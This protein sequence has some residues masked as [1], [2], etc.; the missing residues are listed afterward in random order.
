MRGHELSPCPLCSGCRLTEPDKSVLSIVNLQ[1]LAKKSRKSLDIG[2]VTNTAL[3]ACKFAA[4]WRNRHIAHR[5]AGVVLGRAAKPL[6]EASRQSVRLALAA[7]GKVLDAVSEPYLGS[8]THFADAIAVGTAN[9][10]LYVM[11]D[12]IEAR[13]ERIERLRA[14]QYAPEDFARD[15]RPV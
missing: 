8:T 14:G 13:A 10:L 3:A 6:E 5:D 15:R 11:R 4:D 1:V 12:G 2:E 9:D 7:L